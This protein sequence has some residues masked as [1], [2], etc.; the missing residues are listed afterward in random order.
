MKFLS[1]KTVVKISLSKKCLQQ[2]RVLDQS[3]TQKAAVT[4]NDD[5]VVRQKMMLVQETLHFPARFAY[6]A[7]ER[8]Q[9]RIGIGSL[10]EQSGYGS[11]QFRGKMRS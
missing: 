9:R 11:S 1:G 6:Q 2:I 7:F 10:P 5:G 3:L 4:K 8:N